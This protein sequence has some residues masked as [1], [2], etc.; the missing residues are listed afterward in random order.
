M[1]PRVPIPQRMVLEILRTLRANQSRTGQTLPSRRQAQ[2]RKLPRR[3]Q[4]AIKSFIVLVHFEG[5][6][7]LRHERIRRKMDLH[8]FKLEKGLNQED[9]DRVL[10]PRL[11][12]WSQ[13]LHQG[14]CSCSADLI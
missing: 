3:H 7:Q 10:R 1:H 13:I 4:R 2:L 11:I 5:W 14:R 9:R 8:S 12:S 6:Y